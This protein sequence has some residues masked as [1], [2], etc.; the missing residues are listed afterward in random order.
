IQIWFKQKP[1]LIR[2]ILMDQAATKRRLF[3]PEEVEKLLNSR[4]DHSWMLWS[5]INVELW[6]KIF[7]DEDIRYMGQ[8]G[9]P[10]EK[11]T[12]EEKT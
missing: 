10:L 3:N 8:N 6:F 4:E 5:L 1:H 12:Y 9:R 2:S 7:I 11:V